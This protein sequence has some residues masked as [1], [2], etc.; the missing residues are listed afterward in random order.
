MACT[1]TLKG[2]AGIVYSCSWA[3]TGPLGH[4]LVSG[5]SKGMVVV[6]DTVTGMKKLSQQLYGPAHPVYRVA[7]NPLDENAILTAGGDGMVN[8]ITPAG[9]V[10]RTAR[11]RGVLH[12]QCVRGLRVGGG[13]PG[14]F[15]VLD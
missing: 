4:L 8:L 13:L 9:E 5:S 10:S 3:P 11:C 15:R 6:W 12:M 7:W 14:I 1:Q 2:D